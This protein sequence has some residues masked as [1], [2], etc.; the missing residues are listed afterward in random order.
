MMTRS[1][2]LLITVCW[3]AFISTPLCSAEPQQGRTGKQPASATENKRLLDATILGRPK[4]VRPALD[5]GADP[6]TRDDSGMTPL[7]NAASYPDEISVQLLLE[8]GADPNVREINGLT[9][10]MLTAGHPDSDAGRTGKMVKVIKLLLKHGA[11]INA[12]DSR[13]NSALIDAAWW[14]NARVVQILLNNGADIRMRNKHG[15]TALKMAS[16][17]GTTPQRQQQLQATV[18]LLKHAGANE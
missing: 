8:R 2:L 13:G 7:G 15:S 17:K 3:M 6:N 5:N 12:Q 11:K 1:P 18:K 9:P 14:G 10:I 4:D 16:G